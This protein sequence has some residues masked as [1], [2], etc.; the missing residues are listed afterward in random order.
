MKYVDEFRAKDLVRSLSGRLHEITTRPVRIM[1]VCGTHT[2]SIF[3]HGLR[4]ML[5]PAVELVSGPG[6][7]VCVTPSGVID[8]FV[9][10]A[11]RPG[12][13]IT[14]FG[15]MI[16]VP[17][18]TGSLA[19]ARAGGADVRIVYSPMDALQL[20][21][22]EKERLVVFLAV[23]FETTTPTIA[24]TILAAA[25][26]TTGNFCIFPANKV[27]PPPLDILMQDPE[28]QV[29]ALL[30]PGH[31]SV[32]IGAGAYRFLVDR[33]GLACAVAGFEPTDIL[34]AIIALVEQINRG[35]PEVGNCYGRAVTE[36]GNRKAREMVR[37]VFTPVDSDWRGL[38]TIG[39]SGLTLRREYERFDVTRRLEIRVP[40]SAEPGGCRCGQ[41][42]KGISRP[43]D[44]PLFGSR[45]TPSAPVG[46][47]MVSSEGTC[48]AWY[49][50][51]DTL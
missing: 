35:R 40:E 28:L 49:R 33:Y 5:P 25:K 47:C 32:I 7:P 6:C 45:C 15:D 16:R 51:G 46:P 43:P 44:C 30:C 20:A 48:A 3:R 12:I 37:T 26:N 17:G 24:A 10:L 2:M 29:D 50:Y 41:I 11:S 1:E 42:L 38:G 14:T 36:E 8:A 22:Q 19:D 34:T 21:R 9:E 18:S 31:V 4:R 13:T 27:M 23:G 39:A